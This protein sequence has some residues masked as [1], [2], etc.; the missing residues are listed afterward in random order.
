[1]SPG[2][3]LWSIWFSRTLSTKDEGKEKE[4]RWFQ[5]YQTLLSGTNLIEDWWDITAHLRNRLRKMT[6]FGRQRFLNNFP[7]F[8]FV[9]FRTSSVSRRRPCCHEQE[10][11]GTGK[12]YLHH[13]T[14]TPFDSHTRTLRNVLTL[15]SDRIDLRLDADDV[16]DGKERRVRS[17]KMRCMQTTHTQGSISFF[18]SPSL[19]FFFC[20]ITQREVGCW[21]DESQVSTLPTWISKK[22]SWLDQQ[23]SETL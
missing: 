23:R 14:V 4:R 8:F 20:W 10:L 16:N 6:L 21:K 19:Y 22:A 7:L 17:Q 11:H 18:F 9:Y 13:F 2:S 12:C 5:A 1:M 3:T 15:C